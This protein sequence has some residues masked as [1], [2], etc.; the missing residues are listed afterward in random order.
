MKAKRLAIDAMLAAMCAALGYISIDA[1]VFKFSFENLPIIIGAM[2]F[3]PLDG[4]LIGGIGTFLYQMLRWGIEA[5]TPLWILPYVV[6]GLMVGFFAKRVKFTFKP[7]S[8]GIMLALNAFLI[9]LLNTG[10]LYVDS[11]LKSYPYAVVL[12]SLLLKFAVGAI[13]A[14]VYAAV[15]PLLILALKKAKIYESPLD[16][17]ACKKAEEPQ[18]AECYVTE[19]AEDIEQ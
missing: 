16:L 3:G 8:L 11:W 18:T 7:V 19:K 12:P 15:I 10:A 17:S 13:K 5:S 1:H 4:A 2:L 14:V 6:S 9:T